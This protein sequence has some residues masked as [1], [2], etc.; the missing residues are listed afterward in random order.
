MDGL[1]KRYVLVSFI[2]S[3]WL[4]EQLEVPDWNGDWRSVHYTCPCK[5]RE[6]WS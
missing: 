2:R 4:S 3:E 5:I 6:L 1:G